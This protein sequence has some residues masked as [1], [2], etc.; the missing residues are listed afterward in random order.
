MGRRDRDV[1]WP[2]T[3]PPVWQPTTGRISQIQSFSLRCERF[4][5]HIR[6]PNPW[7]LHQRDKNP[8]SGFKS[9]WGLSPG[10]SKGY[11]ELRYCS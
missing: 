4:V 10:D 3:P 7:D 1:V 5:P 6:R 11:R 9:Q 8:M 2:K